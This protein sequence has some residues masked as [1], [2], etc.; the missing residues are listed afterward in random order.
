M[1]AAS[2]SES[3]SPRRAPAGSAD[4]TRNVR[5]SIRARNFGD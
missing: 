1:A 3:V 5:G 4:T 2:A